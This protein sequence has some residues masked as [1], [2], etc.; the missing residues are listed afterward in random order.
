MKL[1]TDLNWLRVCYSEVLLKK[2]TPN[3]GLG[4][5]NAEKY[6]EHL[7]ARSYTFR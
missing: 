1:F 6:F 3:K 5:K 7:R 2:G 4:H